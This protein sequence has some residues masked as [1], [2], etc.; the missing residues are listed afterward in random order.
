MNR[1]LAYQLAAIAAV[2]DSDADRESLSPLPEEG[3]DEL[4]L[5]DPMSKIDIPRI[6]IELQNMIDLSERESV[7]FRS[8]QPGAMHQGDTKKSFRKNKVR[9]K[10]KSTRKARRKNR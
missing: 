10:R 5:E 8:N 1:F 3:W 4:L 9:K 2:S 6:A 7:F